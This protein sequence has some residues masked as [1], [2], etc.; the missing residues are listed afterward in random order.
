MLLYC[1]M[2]ILRNFFQIVDILQQLYEKYSNNFCLFQFTQRSKWLKKGCTAGAYTFPTQGAKEIL[3][4]IK[5]YSDLSIICF[6]LCVGIITPPYHL[7]MNKAYF[8]KY[9]SFMEKSGYYPFS[10]RAGLTQFSG[11]IIRNTLFFKPHAMY[12]PKS[13]QDLFQKFFAP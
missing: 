3:G 13:T 7:C 8:H 4:K 1:G 10:R 12:N 5:W 6:C 2:Y 11:P 9:T